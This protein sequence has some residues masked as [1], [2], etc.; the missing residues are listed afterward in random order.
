[1]SRSLRIRGAK[2]LRG[3][4]RV[5]G[6]KSIGHRSLLFA[7]LGEGLSTIEGLSHGE[8][9]LSTARALQAMGVD[10]TLQ[11]QGRAQVQGVGLDGLRRSADDIDCGN[12]G[13]S[14]R[15]FAGLLCAQRFGSRL[16]GDGSLCSR[17]M[18]RVVDPLNARGAH[19]EGASGKNP[20]DV[21]PPL[22][23]D[24]LPSAERL[25]GLRYD[26]P[27]ASAQVKS[28]LLLS[29]LYAKGPTALSEPMVSRDHTERML[30]ALGV[31]I[32]TAGPVVVLD[33]A[34]W[35]RR[36]PGRHWQVPSDL[37]S[38]AFVLSAARIVPGSDVVLEQV[39]VNPTR[40][41]FL[42]AM[43]LMGAQV[44]HE[45]KGEVAGGEPLADL[46]VTFGPLR[47]LTIG[48]EL[49]TRMIDEVPIACVLAACA[50]G[51]TEIRDASELR[52][53]ESDRISVMANTLQAF[54]VECQ[55]Y[56]DG[57]RITERPKA[58]PAVVQSQ[59]DHRIAMAAAVLAMATPGLSVIEDVACIETS[60]PG[61]VALMRELGADIEETA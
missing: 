41:G 44:E 54:G 19:I 6:D 56:P 7:A 47:G 28:A 50:Q 10:I 36:W 2:P 27:V 46:R 37:S 18:R 55:Q 30:L 22:N 61:F 5:P 33:P 53:K 21:Y 38:A 39:G 16:T 58:V 3:K 14:M 29:G 9:N 34:G 31:P 42:D 40:T 17:P 1:M 48:G 20:Q 32:E 59:G 13:T 8:D 49:L 52:V 35:D 12:S 43:R 51:V 45:P 15:L 23:I 4:V 11:P 25:A 60:F 26:I 57:L 24:P